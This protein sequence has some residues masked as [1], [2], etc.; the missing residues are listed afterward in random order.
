MLEIRQYNE[1]VDL[2]EIFQIL[3]FMCVMRRFRTEAITFL[4]LCRK[5][6]GSHDKKQ[7]DF[8]NLISETCRE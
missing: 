3:A 7:W 5:R 6:T 8:L 4:H 1:V 2:Q